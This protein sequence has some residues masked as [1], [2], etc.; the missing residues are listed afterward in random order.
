MPHLCIM[1]WSV[2]PGLGGAQV[3]VILGQLHVQAPG[4]LWVVISGSILPRSTW[5]DSLSQA[6]SPNRSSFG[7]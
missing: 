3:V 6:L 7:L 4:H 1:A 2:S 5:K